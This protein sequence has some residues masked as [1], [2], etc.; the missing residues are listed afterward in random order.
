MCVLEEQQG[1]QHQRKPN[2]FYYKRCDDDKR[3][4]E[5]ER[6]IWG[7]GVFKCA[8]LSTSARTAL[9]K[10]VNGLLAPV[11]MFIHPFRILACIYRSRA[12]GVH[13]PFSWLLGNQTCRRGRLSSRAPLLLACRLPGGGEHKGHITAISTT[14]LSVSGVLLRVCWCGSPGHCG[15]DPLS[16]PI[17]T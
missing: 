9:L 5:R 8:S 1:K 13:I 11:N 17:W 16:S 3:S 7:R 12:A 10:R 2:A 6:K 4:S 15:T 14:I